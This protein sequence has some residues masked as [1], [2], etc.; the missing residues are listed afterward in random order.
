MLLIERESTTATEKTVSPKTLEQLE[1][2]Q[3]H[4][5]QMYRQARLRVKPILL[6]HLKKLNAEIRQIKGDSATIH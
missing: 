3:V 2:Y 1:H 5:Q 4:Y 6:K